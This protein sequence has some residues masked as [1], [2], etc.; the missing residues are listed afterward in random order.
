MT[1]FGPQLDSDQTD[2]ATMLGSLTSDRGSMLEDDAPSVD[3]LVTELAD[4]GVW[5]LGTAESAGGGGADAAMTC[6]AHER[7]GRAWPALAWASVQAHAAVDV[8]AAAQG[9]ADLVDDLHQGR[10]AVAVVRSDAAHVHLEWDGDVLRGTVSRIDAASEAPC[11][12]VLTGADTAVLVMPSDM[13]MQPV[14]R[15]GMAGALTRSVVVSANRADVVHLD[16]V[17]TAAALT[18]LRRG[19]AAVA[20]GIA[21]AAADA[22]MTYASERRQFGGPLTNIPVVRQTLRDQADGA[23]AAIAIAWVGDSEETSLTAARRAC[24]EAVDVAASALQSHGGYGYLTEYPAERH[25]RDAISLRAAA[26]VDSSS[27]GSAA[28]HAGAIA[29]R[30]P[31]KED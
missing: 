13:T 2:L 6:V 26:A 29:S 17:D 5:T 23:A 1:W 8:L 21:G 7:I 24:E 14:S 3:G 22:A 9:P 10:A 31:P 19:A 28:F 4:L 27:V 12:M 30:Q 11:L 18:R 25:L 16:G 20:A 15:T